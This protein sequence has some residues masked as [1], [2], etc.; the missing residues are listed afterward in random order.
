MN[1]RTYP[2]EAWTVSLAGVVCKVKIIEARR[3]GYGLKTENG[4]YCDSRKLHDTK[5]EAII[6]ALEE[7]GAKEAALKRQML[8]LE[9]KRAALEKARIEK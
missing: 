1:T 3:Y 2:Y 9:K 4:S 6:A 5:A 8:R 7:L